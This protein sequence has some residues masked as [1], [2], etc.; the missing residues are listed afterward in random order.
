MAFQCYPGSF[1]AG[2]LWAH[3]AASYNPVVDKGV[4]LMGMGV[5]LRQQQGEV[6]GASP[7]FA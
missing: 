1:G 2:S 5:F 7:R 6:Q 4:N 3:D